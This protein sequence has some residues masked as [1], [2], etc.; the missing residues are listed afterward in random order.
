MKD[1]HNN[2]N[3]S[4][5]FVP[6]TIVNDTPVVGNIIDMQGYKSL[7]FVILLGQ[8]LDS[9][10]TFTVLVEEGNDSGLS[11]ATVVADTDLLGTEVAAGFQFDSDNEIRQI[12]YIGNK[13]YVR[14][15]IAATNNTLDCDIAVLA[16]QGHAHNVPVN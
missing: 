8:I 2:L 5:A 7:E 15:T 16:V 1:L 14:M 3:M 9:N 11:D 6:Q 4:A 12:G 13:R 10:A